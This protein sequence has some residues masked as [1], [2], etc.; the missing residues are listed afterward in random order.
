MLH[1][2]LA[3]SIYSIIMNSFHDTKQMVGLNLLA[4]ITTPDS[5]DYLYCFISC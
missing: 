1:D 2:K 5:V 3:V 4:D